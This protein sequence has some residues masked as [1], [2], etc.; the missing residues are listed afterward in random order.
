LGV[1]ERIR[2]VGAER[3]VEG[4]TVIAE[5]R[6]LPSTIR[7][8]VGYDEFWPFFMDV[9][10]HVWTRR[11]HGLATVIGLGC[12]LIAFP[13][14]L[15][16]AWLVVAL[17]IAYPIAWLSHFLFERRRPA[18]FTNPFWAFLCDVEMLVLMAQGRLEAELESLRRD[19]FAPP[20]PGRRAWRT[21]GQVVMVAYVATFFLLELTDRTTFSFRTLF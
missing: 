10:M 16:S 18:A 11:L 6:A 1:P 19:R 17:A 8:A 21:F 2:P 5:T 9:H 4:D 20:D 13:W 3:R 7:H 12:A 15:N 14:T